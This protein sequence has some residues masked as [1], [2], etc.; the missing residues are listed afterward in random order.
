MTGA[1]SSEAVERAVRDAGIIIC[2]WGAH[3][4]HLDQDETMLGWLDHKSDL[5]H[6][7]GRTKDGHPRHPLYLTAGARP[8]RFSGRRA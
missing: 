5:I 7:L 3:G 6:C 1:S 4:G 2:A 8:V